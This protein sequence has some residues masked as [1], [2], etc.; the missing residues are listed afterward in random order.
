MNLFAPLEKKKHQIEQLIAWMWNGMFL[1]DGPRLFGKNTFDFYFNIVCSCVT[2]MIYKKSEK[3]AKVVMI[4]NMRNGNLVIW[5]V[6]PFQEEMNHKGNLENNLEN[7]S[8]RMCK[9]ERHD[10]FMC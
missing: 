5:K 1:K 4:W 6:S 3:N 7:N 8:K 10:W 9:E 2:P